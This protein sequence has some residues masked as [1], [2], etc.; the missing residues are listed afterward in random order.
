VRNLESPRGFL[1]V[2]M[3][4]ALIGLSNSKGGLIEPRL[5]VIDEF[6]KRLS[7]LTWLAVARFTV[8][9]L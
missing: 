5:R 9:L 6:G 2:S 1:R 8:A 4:I 3:D 7:R